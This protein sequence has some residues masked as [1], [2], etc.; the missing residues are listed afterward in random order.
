MVKVKVIHRNPADYVQQKPGQ[1]QRVVRNFDPE[2]H[3]FEREREY[4]RALNAVKLQKMF[5]KPLLFCMEG[6]R[7]GVKCMTRG[8]SQAAAVWTGSCNGEVAEWNLGATKKCVKVFQAHDGFVRGLCISPKDQRLL[9]G[10]DDRKIKIWSLRSP[11]AALSTLDVAALELETSS[12]LRR[13]RGRK[14]EQDEPEED[15]AA[16]DDIEDGQTAH[17]VPALVAETPTAVFTSESVVTS[18]DH[19]WTKPLFVSTGEDVSVWDINRSAPLHNFQWGCDLVHSARFNPA[20]PCL[21]AATGAD[22]S[23]G[24]YDLRANTPIRK[25]MMKMR[26][27]A[28]CWNPMNPP[29]FTTA[30]EDQN[31]YTFDMRKLSAPLMI[32]R[33]FVNAVL[34][35][36]YSPTG[37]EFVAASFDGTIRMFKVDEARSRDVYHTRRMQSVLCCRYSA[38]SRFV[39]SGSADMCVRVWKTDA[40]A[41]L[42]PRTHRERQAMAYR[43]TLTEKFSHLKEIKRIARHHHVPKL[44]KK[45]QEKKREM[46]DARRRREENRRK[47]SKPGSVPFVSVKKAAVYREIE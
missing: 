34:D 10:G 26:S 46:T 1:L 25:V 47:H 2:V 29:K 35:V 15:G 24:L 16:D 21:I 27:N 45:T 43:K 33:D 22:N 37:Q 5:A 20:E 31:L 42:G 13:G 18:L 32:H 38:D 11:S 17:A 19:H 28:V 3:P 8:K 39:I 6:H 9:T 40:S 41:Q 7:D 12:V 14:S 23:V 44:I 36:D 4:A 30:S